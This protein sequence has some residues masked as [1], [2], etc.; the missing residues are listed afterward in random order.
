MRPPFLYVYTVNKT[1]PFAQNSFMKKCVIIL[2]V[3]A[4]LTA[5]LTSCTTRDD[6]C[7]N[8]ISEY[9]RL[10]ERVKFMMV[11]E[12]TDLHS[13]FTPRGTSVEVEWSSDN[14]AVASV[15]EGR[16]TANS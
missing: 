16:V 12:E 13:V 15:E 14:V 1:P 2:L 11:G 10:S 8:E 4:S 6:L 3:A 7:E 9:V 5:V